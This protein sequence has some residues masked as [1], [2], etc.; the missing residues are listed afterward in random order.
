MRVGWIN[1]NRSALLQRV[2][3]LVCLC[4]GKKKVETL[5]F[6]ICVKVKASILE[7]EIVNTLVLLI[8]S[9]D[10]NNIIFDAICCCS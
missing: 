5:P 9:D 10:S 6:G 4:L 3:P 7:D 1:E 8:Y 2:W